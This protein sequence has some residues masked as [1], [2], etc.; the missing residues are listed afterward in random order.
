MK[1][2]ILLLTL[3]PCIAFGQTTAIPDANF[4]QALINLGHDT[5]TPDGSVLTASIDTVTYLWMQNQSISDLTGIQD[6]TALTYLDCRYNQ[7]TSLDVSNNTALSYLH[8][9]ENQLT[10]LNI[11]GATALDYLVCY[12]NHLTS[13]DGSQNTALTY[14]SC[15]SNKLT[16]L[17]VSNNTVLSVLG[18]H[19][20]QISSLDISINITLNQL[21]CGGNQLASLEVSQNTALTELH[22]ES[23]QLSS[24]DLSNNTALTYL[25]CRYNQLTCLNVKNGNNTSFTYFGAWNNPNLTCIEVV[26]STWATANWTAANWHIDY[27]ASFSEYC[28]NACSGV[29]VSIHKLPAPNKE[30]L[31]ITDILGRTTHPAPNQILIYKYTDGSAEKKIQLQR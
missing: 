17:D 6:F 9:G 30:L 20:N 7:L 11:N 19:N 23:N 31:S 24:L 26:D 2:L 12:D 14:L 15:S 16:S 28:N 29:P 13:L 8:C 25:D 10:S 21:Y 3:A 1:K 5:G 22:C 27:T 4:E 18:C